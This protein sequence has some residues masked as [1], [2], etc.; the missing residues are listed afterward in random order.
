MRFPFVYTSTTEKFPEFNCILPLD[1]HTIFV[2]R[3]FPPI[4]TIWQ[5][6]QALMPPRNEA[7]DKMAFWPR[8]HQHLNNL[9]CVLCVRRPLISL[10]RHKLFEF[11]GAIYQRRR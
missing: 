2:R 1:D 10:V 3:G 8:I 11:R 6:K 4:T 9:I 7:N 5:D